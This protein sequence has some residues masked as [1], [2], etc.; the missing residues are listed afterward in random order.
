MTILKT[1][2][3]SVQH[4]PN[5][6][7][8]SF[9]DITIQ[10]GD[11]ILLLG[12]SGCGK[13]TLLSVIAGLLSPQSGQ[14]AVN[15]TDFYA[16]SPKDRDALRGKVF[17]FVFQN[18]HLLPALTIRQNILLAADMAGLK[19]QDGRLEKLLSSLGLSDKS[20]R[21]PSALSHGEQQRAALARA[22]LN[23]PALIIADEPTSALD[24]KNADAVMELL[25]RQSTET[26][27]ALL[28]ATHDTRIKHRFDTIITLS[29]SQQEAA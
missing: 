8:L 14:V 18:L 27:A 3:I 19:P 29:S 1:T 10:K 24:D 16:L 7:R 26:G 17:G 20:D 28:V 15:D 21:K 9:P 2:N 5:A 22:V 6:P 12:A 25:E 11:K 4:A 23:S 13:T